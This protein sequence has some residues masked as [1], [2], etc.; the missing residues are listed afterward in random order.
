MIATLSMYDWPEVR[1]DTDA[2]WALLRDGLRE[3]GFDAPET[4]TRPDDPFEAWL[5]PDLLIGET[6][7]YPLVTALIDK[8]RY[9]AT[10]VHDAPGCSRGT[11]RS[12]IARRAPGHQIPA[13]ATGGAAVTAASVEGRQ[14]ANSS[15]SLSGYIA[16]AGDG[17]HAGLQMPAANGISWTGSHRASI[18]AVANGDAE[19]A[20]IDCVTWALAQCQEP[21]CEA[22]YVAGW[23]AARP[24]LPLITSSKTGDRDLQ[25][26]RRSVLG[27]IP[28]VVLDEPFSIGPLPDR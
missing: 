16:L 3:A 7:S 20:A 22:L 21:A 18:R 17:A 19:F 27:A 14:A 28:A 5:S 6:C 26:M 2:R 12:A 1:A 24:A 10:P 9:V 13:P 15:D 4:L 23:T 8:V 25:R 11:Y